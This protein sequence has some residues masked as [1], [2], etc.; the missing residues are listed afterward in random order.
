M[1]AECP[2]SMI[3]K[4][5]GPPMM[6]RSQMSNFKPT[7]LLFISYTEEQAVVSENKGALS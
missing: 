4:R 6:L 5:D 1:R 3:D 2:K 7:D